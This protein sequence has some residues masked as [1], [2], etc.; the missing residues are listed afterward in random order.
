M[1]G[2][3]NENAGMRYTQVICQAVRE[4]LKL[5]TGDGAPSRESMHH[6]ESGNAQAEPTERDQSNPDGQRESNSVI[7]R[8]C[9]KEAG[10]TGQ[11]P[12]RAGVQSKTEHRCRQNEKLDLTPLGPTGEAPLEVEPQITDHAS[13]QDG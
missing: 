6:C 11:V 3:T 8:R 13:D 2:R 12:Q 5:R 10:A 4:I 9:T 1:S 7:P